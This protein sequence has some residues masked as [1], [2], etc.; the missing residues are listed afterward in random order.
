MKYNK[1]I[2]AEFISRTNRFIAEVKTER[3]TEIAHVKNT[4]R[5]RELLIPGCRVWLSV[6]DSVTRKTAYDLIAVEKTL[7]SGDSL[8]INMDSSAPNDVAEEWL[9]SGA[10]FGTDAK[11]RREVTKGDSRYDFQIIKD[12]HESFLEV[13]GV[14]L[15]EGGVALFPDAPTER[16]V[17]H[18]EGL[19]RLA[20]EG[21]GAYILFVVQMKGIKYFTPNDK[22]HPEFAAALK[23]ANESGVKILSIDSH[24]T[25]FGIE[26]GSS[27]EIRL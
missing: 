24:V 26:Y 25:P 8:L 22:T 5:C 18:I 11:I 20:R 17:K 19:I 10:L 21:V 9:R 23:R 12:G 15:E 16:G 14:T 27:V 1:I 4:G 3:G 2:E 7:A 13:K 6:S